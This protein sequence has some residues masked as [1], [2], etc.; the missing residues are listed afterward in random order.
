MTTRHTLLVPVEIQAREFDAKLLFA[1]FATERD[2]DV[3]VG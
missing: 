2:L 1:C 3:V